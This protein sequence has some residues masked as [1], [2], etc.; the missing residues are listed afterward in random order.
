MITTAIETLNSSN[1]KAFCEH[2]I[3]VA[4]GISIPRSAKQWTMNLMS[5]FSQLA[6]SI[7]FKYRPKFCVHMHQNEEASCHLIII[8]FN[9]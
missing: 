2:L 1:K 7:G 8:I 3:V 6:R 5:V 4:P 9:F